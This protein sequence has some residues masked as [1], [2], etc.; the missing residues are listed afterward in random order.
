MRS[1]ALAALRVIESKIV[2]TTISVS[3][4]EMCGVRSATASINPLFVIVLPTA[5]APTGPSRR[6][7]FAP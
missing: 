1:P 6:R 4:F 2:L 3:F 7:S 5:A